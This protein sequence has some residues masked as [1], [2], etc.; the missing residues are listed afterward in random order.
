MCMVVSS[1][2]KQ[3][4]VGLWGLLV[5]FPSLISEPQIPVGDLSKT[6]YGS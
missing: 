5:S 1:A 2:G 3:S 4:Q 6:E